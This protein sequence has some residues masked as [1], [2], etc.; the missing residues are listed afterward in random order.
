MVEIM[1]FRKH[2][3]RVIEVEK[4]GAKML[5]VDVPIEGDPV[6]KGWTTHYY[7]GASIF[8][9]TP[10]DEDSVMRANKPYE[11]PSPYRLPAPASFDPGFDGD[12]HAHEDFDDFGPV[13][14]GDLNVVASGDGGKSILAEQANAERAAMVGPEIV[15]AYTEDNCPGHVAS[16]TDPKIC[17]RCGVHSSSLDPG[18][19]DAGRAEAEALE[20]DA[21]DL[22]R[23][24]NPEKSVFDC[25]EAEKETYRERVRRGE[26]VTFF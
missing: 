21:A 16:Q 2:A 24:E 11:R 26:S 1:G 9:V 20:K 4:F 19:P 18:E 6:A 12:N 10:T 13:K 15:Y 17:G 14:P 5:R 25:D 22:W 23:S 3:G 7:S 8:A